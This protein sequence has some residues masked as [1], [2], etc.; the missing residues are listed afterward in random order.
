MS[1]ER[2]LEEAV[3][4]ELDEL[5]AMGDVEIRIKDGVE[6]YSLTEQG[7]RNL[8]QCQAEQRELN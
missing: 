7:Y 1:I 6:Y 3:A 2:D 8:G 4:L 5:V